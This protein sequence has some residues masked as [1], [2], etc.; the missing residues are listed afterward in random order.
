MC[1]NLTTEGGVVSPV[2]TD[3]SL[4][5][6]SSIRLQTRALNRR[7]SNM[8]AIKHTTLIESVW[9]DKL[10]ALGKDTKCGKKHKKWNAKVSFLIF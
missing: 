8:T 7:I 2:Q 9:R 10:V 3:P 5:T 1:P 6:G 4:G